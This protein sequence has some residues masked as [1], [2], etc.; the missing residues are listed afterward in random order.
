V[1]VGWSY[2]GLFTIVAL[3]FT[4]TTLL[5]PVALKQ[6]KIVP[7]KPSQA[8]GEPFECGMQTIGKTWIQFNFRYYYYALVFL[9]LDVMVVFIYPWAAGFR[10][11][12]T[13]GFI[14]MLIFIVL[15][16][17]GYIYAWKKKALEW[18]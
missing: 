15:I 6:L 3:G 5:L 13:T 16:V 8:K 14:I 1:L 10:L 9:A 11:V 2:I 17:V 7:D 4:I 12:S 18:K